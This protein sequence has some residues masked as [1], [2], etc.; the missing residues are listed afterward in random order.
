[1]TKAKKDISPNPAKSEA[2]FLPSDPTW[3]G[4]RRIS[5]KQAHDWGLDEV[6]A[7]IPEDTIVMISGTAP[8]RSRRKKP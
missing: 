8:P 6:A 5:D 4:P 7:K 1:M 3:R 2:A